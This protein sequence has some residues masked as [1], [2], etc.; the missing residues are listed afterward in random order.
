[1]MLTDFEV[2][3]P[4]TDFGMIQRLVEDQSNISLIRSNID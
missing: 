3:I 1:M 4:L 2:A